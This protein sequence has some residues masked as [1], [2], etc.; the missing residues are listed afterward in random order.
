MRP[1]DIEIGEYYRHR[2]NQ[3]YGYAK[4]VKVL[5]AKQHPN[6]HTY[7]VVECE[8]MLYKDDSLI[9][10]KYFRPCDL[11]RCKS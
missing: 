7:A 10:T 5:K 11:E 8:W 1:Q 9:M 4:A 3:R 2:D 6:T